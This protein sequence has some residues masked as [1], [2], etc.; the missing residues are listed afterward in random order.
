MDE[1]VGDKAGE[2]P[3]TVD[4]SDSSAV[5]GLSED[6]AKASTALR[7]QGLQCLRAGDLAQA[8]DL[9]SRAA[10]QDPDDPRT[11][12]GLGI[13]LQG[14]RRHAEALA[15]L[16][17][18]Q[19]SL[20]KDPLP[21]LHASLSQL[22]LGKAE[23]ALEAASEACARAPQ[24]PQAHSAHGQALMALNEPARAEQAFAAAL[25]RAPQWADV[26]VLCGAARYRQG[27]IEGAKAAM[28]EA[29][30]HAPDHAAAKDNLAALLRI[31]V[32]ELAAVSA[33]PEARTS[34]GVDGHAAKD[35]AILRAWRPKDPAASLGLAV[36]FLSKKPA[37]AKLPFGEWSQVL[38]YQVTRGH[39][40]F[41]VDHDRRVRGFLG[42]ALTAQALAEHWVEGRAGLRND[43]C[44]EGDCVIV[45]AFAADTVGANRFI[46][47]T[48]RKLFAS[49]RTLYFK[50]HYPDGRT[51]PMRLSVNE[52]VA[53]HLARSVSRREGN[54]RV[55]R[56]HRFLRA[57]VSAASSA[58]AI[59]TRGLAR[60]SRPG[61]LEARGELDEVRSASARSCSRSTN[62]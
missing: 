46:V 49:K 41:V 5:R 12:L 54:G 48:M 59:G 24:L 21:F 53:G 7:E 56:T 36:E 11:Q 38:F 34:S 29:L 10:A 17:G 13:A 3:V 35:D 23:A 60:C 39:F 25:R 51:R 20:T 8:I 47:D 4:A 55:Q 19:K 16:E 62:A 15:S 1:G 42:W 45:N 44:R 9:L 31:G 37:F 14:M 52:F 33:T 28:R 61:I 50:R 18:A 30:R 6:D 26:W 58:S 22:A 40:F 27:A 57:S 32:D 43:E 2:E